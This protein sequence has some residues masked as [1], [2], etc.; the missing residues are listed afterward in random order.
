LRKSQR[1]AE[2][3]ANWRFEK[4]KSDTLALGAALNA[5]KLGAAK[6]AFA[7]LKQH[8]SPA[9]SDRDAGLNGTPT[10]PSVAS[11]SAPAGTSSDLRALLAMSSVGGTVDLSA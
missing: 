6:S 11:N 7:T 8:M 3:T 2:P 1:L 10:M 9:H 5:G 4:L